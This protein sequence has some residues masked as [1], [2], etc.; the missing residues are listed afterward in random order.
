MEFTLINIDIGD[1]AALLFL[2]FWILRGRA[3]LPS[4]RPPETHPTPP[5]KHP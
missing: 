2:L 1:G 4:N 5:R 3:P